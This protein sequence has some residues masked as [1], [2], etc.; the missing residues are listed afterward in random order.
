MTEAEIAEFLAGSH[1]MRLATL[2][3]DGGPHI[4]SMWYGLLDG[5]IAFSSYA[6]SQKVVNVRRDPRV[7]CQVELGEHPSEVKGVCVEGLARVVDAGPE[8]EAVIRAVSIQS[9]GVEPTI[10]SLAA[11]GAD[12]RAAVIVEPTRVASWDHTKIDYMRGVI[13]GE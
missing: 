11:M 6:K 2:R 1:L 8:L 9:L 10:E 4:V 13:P 7:A 3:A 12:K 5:R